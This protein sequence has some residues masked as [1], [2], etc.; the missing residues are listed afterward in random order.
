[1]RTFV[2]FC[3]HCSFRRL[4][5]DV[6]PDFPAAPLV[7]QLLEDAAA[8][9][10]AFELVEA[11]AG[12]GEQDDVAGMGG[13][14]D[15]ADGLVEGFAGVDRDHAAEL[16]LDFGGGGADGV[17]GLDARAKQ[18]GELGVVGVLVFAAEDEVNVAGECGDGLGGGVDVGGLGV[19]VDFDAVEGGD[20]FEAM[21]DGLELLDGGADGFGGAPA[22]RAAQTAASTFSTLCS[23][24]SGMLVS[25][26]TCSGAASGA[27]RKRMDPPSTHAP[28]STGCSSENQ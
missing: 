8:V 11:G 5:L 26:M 4:R 7:Y 14:G 28:C 3:I 12:G 2:R 6:L 20:V 25:G 16:R 1:M 9:F 19:V 24:L 15:G 22:R 17:D 27:E 13:G 23:P 18:I 21:L 10:V